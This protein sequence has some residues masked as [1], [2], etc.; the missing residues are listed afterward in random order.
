MGERRQISVRFKNKNPFS[1]LPC[2]RIPLLFLL[3]SSFPWCLPVTYNL[4][5]HSMFLNSSCILANNFLIQAFKNTQEH[6]RKERT[7]KR[8][9]RSLSIAVA[10]CFPLLSPLFRNEPGTRKRCSCILT[11]IY[12]GPIES[13]LSSSGQEKPCALHCQRTRSDRAGR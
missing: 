6:L 2:C 5:I 7:K 13:A 10:M 12:T 9:V 1:A 3:Y 8:R 11:L 4:G